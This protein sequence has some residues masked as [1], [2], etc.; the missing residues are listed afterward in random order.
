M[1]YFKAELKG[2]DVLLSWKTASEHNNDYFTIEKTLDGEEFEAIGVVNGAGKS[3]SPRNYELYDFNI[4]QLIN[5]YRLKQ[6]DYDGNYIYSKIVSVDNRSTLGN[7]EIVGIYNL[8]GQ[9]IDQYYKGLVI[10]VYSD[11][12]SLK[13]IQE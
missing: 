1:L 8:L 11:G 5:Y 13:M 12:S 2:R 9:K 6:T 7:K 4:L 3:I 10:I